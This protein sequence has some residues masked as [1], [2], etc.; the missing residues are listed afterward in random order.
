MASKKPEGKTLTVQGVGDA[1]DPDAP[2]GKT[3]TVKAIEVTVDPDAMD[4]FELLELLT[5]V[6]ENA[7]LIPKAFR[8]VLGEESGRVLDELRN[9]KGR[10]TIE[11]A[12]AFFT[13]LI[14]AISPKS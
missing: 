1:V 11:A 5:D 12:L 2:E 6:Q 3:L 14:G 13:E 7:M 8:R 4:D 9:E 10:V